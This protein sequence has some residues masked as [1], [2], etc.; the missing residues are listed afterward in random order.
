MV[1]EAAGQALV[2]AILRYKSVYGHC[3]ITG[4][5]DWSDGSFGRPIG[6]DAKYL[7]AKGLPFTQ[8]SAM[9]A[10]LTDA[11][12]S[13]DKREYAR[14]T[15]R[16]YFANVAELEAHKERT[17]GLPRRLQD[18]SAYRRMMRL[19]GSWQ[20]LPEPLTARL[21]ALGLRPPADGEDGGVPLSAR[22]ATRRRRLSE[23]VAEVEAHKEQTG[24]LPRF[25]EH[26]R[27]YRMTRRLLAGWHDTPQPLQQRMQAICMEFASAYVG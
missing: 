13:W 20:S 24:A 18:Y 9:G 16:R 3:D 27:L 25:S 1:G 21:E 11:G 12:F 8:N 17:G 2:A 4:S 5:D 14:K 19:V 15:R 6:V 26:C 10:R 23:H 7:R 22:E